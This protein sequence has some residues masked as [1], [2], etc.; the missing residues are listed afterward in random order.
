[1][2]DA[3]AGDI[4]NA[5]ELGHYQSLSSLAVMAMVLGITSPLILAS[6]M[7]IVLPVTGIAVAI[8]A[9]VKIHSAEGSLT[10]TL[11]AKVGLVLCVCSLMLPL[12]K[13]Y[14]R[15]SVAVESSSAVAEEWI[16]HICTGEL[17]TA[18]L[19]VL[20]D[21]LYELTVR[22]TGLGRSTAPANTVEDGIAE[23][24]GNEE[25]RVIAQQESSESFTLEPAMTVYVWKAN[26]PEV[27]LHYT[28]TREGEEADSLCKVLLVRRPTELGSDLWFIKQWD[29]V[30]ETGT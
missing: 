7:W 4:R 12:T 22:Q 14:V 24:K 29:V 27:L 15:D 21:T 16:S 23:F 13:N 28:F 6:S 2:A 20:P 18:A 19:M 8:V 11:M 10:G 26:R 17:D 1:M 3:M 30:V 9:L 5:D 25:V